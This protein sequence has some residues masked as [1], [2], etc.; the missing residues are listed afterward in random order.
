MKSKHDEIGLVTPA[1]LQ[2]MLKEDNVRLIDVREPWE[3]TK[4]GKIGPSVNIPCKNYVV[5]RDV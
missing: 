2:H 3:L 1:Q 5:L 4:E